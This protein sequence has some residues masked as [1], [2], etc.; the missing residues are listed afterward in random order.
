LAM[1]YEPGAMIY[2]EGLLLP[3]VG[4]LLLGVA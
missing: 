4:D 1:S 3:D 2:R